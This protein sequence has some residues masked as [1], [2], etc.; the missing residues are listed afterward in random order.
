M[1]KFGKIALGT[2]AVFVGGIWA[3]QAVDNNVESTF[4]EVDARERPAPLANVTL[5]IAPEIS[6][7]AKPIS[8]PA[9]VG[10]TMLEQAIFDAFPETEPTTRAAKTKASQAS[11]F[12][13]ATINLEGHLCAQPAA[14]R[15]ADASH[16][17]VGCVTLRNGSGKSIYLVNV[18]TGSVTPI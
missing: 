16:Y 2:A 15:Q 12:L 6:S 5:G 14:T 13:S 10:A 17:A 4:A 8:A 1:G 9:K 18:R 11:D 3:L 7:S